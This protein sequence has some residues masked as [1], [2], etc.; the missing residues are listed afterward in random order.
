MS[1]HAWLDKKRLT[2]QCNLRRVIRQTQIF[3]SSSRAAEKTTTR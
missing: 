1:P 2:P 3:K